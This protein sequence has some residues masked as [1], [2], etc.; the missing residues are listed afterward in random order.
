MYLLFPSSVRMS[1]GFRSAIC[2]WEV[3][4][5]I[6]AVDW[7]YALDGGGLANK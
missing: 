2:R 5:L 4:D 7:F 1:Q 6:Q 3:L